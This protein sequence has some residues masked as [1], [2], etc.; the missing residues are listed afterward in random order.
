MPH[1]SLLKP[2]THRGYWH[3]YMRQ[4]TRAALIQVLACRLFFDKP[5]AKQMLSYSQMD[6]Q[7]IWGILQCKFNQNAKFS[8][9]PKWIWKYLHNSGLV[10]VFKYQCVFDSKVFAWK[11]SYHCIGKRHLPN[12]LAQ[13]C[14]D[15]KVHGA[16]MGPTWA[17]SAPGGPH[18][19]L[20]NLAIWDS[21]RLKAE[22]PLYWKVPLT[23]L[24]STALTKHT[25]RPRRQWRLPLFGP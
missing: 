10:L 22:L 3:K 19:S 13:H 6:P 21:F 17:L 2:K 1:D 5:L 7:V 11:L 24:F 8:L 16:N 12:C 4:W 15:S 25:P 9:S 14:P 23:P 18:I 20:M